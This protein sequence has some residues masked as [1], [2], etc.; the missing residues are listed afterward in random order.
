MPA[1]SCNWRKFE[2]RR[3]FIADDMYEYTCNLA[4]HLQN[5]DGEVLAIISAV[6]LRPL[7]VG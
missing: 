2:P 6:K 4:C 3:L 7:V 5:M 1:S